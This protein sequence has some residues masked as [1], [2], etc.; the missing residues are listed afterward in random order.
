[1]IDRLFSAD[2]KRW[3]YRVGIG[4]AAGIY[5]ALE[6]SGGNEQ[7]AVEGVAMG[8]FATGLAYL[9]EQAAYAPKQLAT[10]VRNWRMR[11]EAE[12]CT[13]S[14]KLAIEDAQRS[15]MPARAVDVDDR[16]PDG[17]SGHV[18]IVGRFM[19]LVPVVLNRPPGYPCEKPSML[20]IALG[21][22]GMD[23]TSE[24]KNSPIEN[25]K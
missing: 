1:M 4:A 15:A 2:W 16:C 5:A 3:A 22:E 19:G 25:L 12:A 6:S 11:D 18:Y 24:I 10:I 20:K 7:A 14:A 23:I 13:Y 17:S 21:L 9:V 8:V